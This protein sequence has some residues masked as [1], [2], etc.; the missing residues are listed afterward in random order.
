M[1]MVQCAIKDYTMLA[2]DKE[3]LDFVIVTYNMI[4]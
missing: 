3:K 1:P 2:S 4:R